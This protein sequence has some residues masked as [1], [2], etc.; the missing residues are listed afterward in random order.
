MGNLTHTHTDSH[1][2][3]PRAGLHLRGGGH[4][5]PPQLNL[6]P[7]PLQ[8]NLFPLTLGLVKSL[9]LLEHLT[10]FSCSILLEGLCVCETHHPHC[11][12]YLNTSYNKKKKHFQKY[13]FCPQIKRLKQHNFLFLTFRFLSPSVVFPLTLKLKF[14]STLRSKCTCHL[15]IVFYQELLQSASLC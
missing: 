7:P 2:C 1:V 15:I 3:T 11:F 6:A 8:L 5:P 12:R 4:W 10:L 13:N 14:S 9:T